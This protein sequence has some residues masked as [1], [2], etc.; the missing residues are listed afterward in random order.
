MHF[1]ALA[2]LALASAVSA[3][4]I[5]V[6]VGENMGVT[7]NPPNVTAAVGDNVVFQFLSKNHTVTQS[8]F[9]N[10]CVQ[11]GI[12]SDFQ[13]V[14]ANATQIP[15]WSFTVNNAS[16]PLWFFCRQT[17][18]CAKGMVFS[19][20]APATGKTFDAFKAA[21]IASGTTG[22]AGTPSASGTPPPS[23]A[24]ATRATSAGL[25][26]VAAGFIAGLLL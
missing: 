19:V 15:E 2:S 22:S 9:A 25:L 4:D 13:F 17:G 21:A 6:K 8:T 10:P 1:F 11:Q 14:P 5:L 3:A 20:N 23:G 24:L 12:D 7:Y 16:A 18:H 26:A